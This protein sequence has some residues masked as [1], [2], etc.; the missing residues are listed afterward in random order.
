MVGLKYVIIVDSVELFNNL[1]FLPWPDTGMAIICL[2]FD[3]LM[4]LMP[5]LLD[6]EGLSSYISALEKR[7]F[8]INNNSNVRLGFCKEGKPAQVSW[9]ARFF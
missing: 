2:Q 4:K 9:E 8:I 1:D 5:F 6:M 3:F 7:G